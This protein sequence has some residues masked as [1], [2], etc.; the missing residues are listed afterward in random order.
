MKSAE[1]ENNKQNVNDIVEKSYVDLAPVKK[2]ES[3]D[4]DGQ[5]KSQED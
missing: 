3:A 5:N 1:N 2:E 4:F